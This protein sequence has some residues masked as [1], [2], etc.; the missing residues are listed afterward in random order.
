MG[1]PAWGNGFH[2]GVGKGRVE[3][4]LIGVAISVASAGI[5]AGGRWLAKRRGT[6]SQD[7]ATDHRPSTD[8]AD[9]STDGD[10]R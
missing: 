8:S 3:G 10:V 9:G 2:K 6:G 4:V 7:P 5:T 1:N